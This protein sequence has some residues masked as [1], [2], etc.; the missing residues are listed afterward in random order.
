MKTRFI[1]DVKYNMR[2]IHKM[3]PSFIPIV[4]ISI[5]IDTFIPF[6]Q[7]ILSARI[8]D[9]LVKNVDMMAIMKNVFIMVGS[10]FLMDM[11]SR[12]L[13]LYGSLGA[14][15]V[16]DYKNRDLSDKAIQMDYDLLERNSTMDLIAKAEEGGEAY[17]GLGS[18]CR[19]VISMISKIISI[20]C[21]ILSLSGL[22]LTVGTQNATVIVANSIASYDNILF[23]FMNSNWSSI[24]LFLCIGISVWMNSRFDAKIGKIQYDASMKNIDSSRIYWFFFNLI[25][26]YSAGKDIRIFRTDKLIE[27]QAY[28]ARNKIE[29]IKKETLK[30]T[31]PIYFKATILR[32]VFVLIAYVFVGLKAVYG[33]ISLGELTK[34]VGMILM[35]QGHMNSL[36]SI[37]TQLRTHN[38][39]LNHYTKY[40]NMKNEKYEGTLPV[41]KRLDQEYELEF[42]NVSFHYPNSDQ[43]ILNHISFHLEVGKKLAIVGQNG[44]GKTTFIKLLCRLYDPTEGEILLNGINIK[45]YDYDEYMNIFSVIFQDYKLFSFSVAENVAASHDY[46]EEKVYQSLKAAGIGE[47]IK[48]LPKGIHTKLFKD[49]Q[50]DGEEGIEISGGEKQKIAL[51]RALYKEAPIVILDE[52]TSALDPLA[53]QDIYERFNDMVQDKTAIFISH[54]MSSCRFCNDILVFDH[55]QII[56]RGSHNELVKN[57]N[58]LYYKMWSAQAKY[59]K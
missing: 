51:A 35:M 16:S 56:Q 29:T 6:V 15:I 44:A 17:G 3:V 20:L 25:F 55:G 32:N 34:Y 28:V 53:E 5:L 7:I 54:R 43:M 49:Q 1:Q 4:F 27:Q 21:A 50:E 33:I 13:S 19:S 57:T 18:Y 36:F 40:H 11:L 38:T 8:L 14:Q 45:K 10:T 58:G 23:Q 31:S 12:I 9:Q 30:K 46:D 42:K 39:Y 52:P 59:Y 22:F 48:T 26:H 41:E 37:I 47:R 2:M 24:C